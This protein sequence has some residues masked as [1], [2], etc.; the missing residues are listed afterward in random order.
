MMPVLEWYGW[1]SLLCLEYCGKQANISSCFSSMNDSS[2]RLNGRYV[3]DISDFSN[4]RFP[5]ARNNLVALIYI[6]HVSDK[7]YKRTNLQK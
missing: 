6:S 2:S 3:I 1:V 4:K 5:H 7:L